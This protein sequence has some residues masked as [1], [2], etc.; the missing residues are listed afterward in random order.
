MKSPTSPRG[1][2]VFAGILACFALAGSAV[3]S[4]DNDVPRGTLTVDRD[5][6][7]VGAKSQ[8]N[9]NITYPTKAKDLVTKDPNGNC[10]TKTRVRMKVRVLAAAFGNDTRFC[11]VEGTIVVDGKVI[12]NG[13]TRNGGTYTMFKGTQPSVKPSQIVF[14]KI[15]EK[16]AKISVTGYAYDTYTRPT[17][18]Y[19]CTTTK[20][21]KSVV[22]LFDGEALPAHQASMYPNMQLNALDYIANY[23]DSSNRAKIGINQ[24]IFLG[25]FN[26]YG[27]EGYDLNDYVIIV[28]LS[29]A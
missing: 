10:T 12:E 27:S 6:I 8:L 23:L 13:R 22:A 28:T 18:K 16:D 2:A 15:I 14:D 7:R 20:S 1:G 19:T 24:V 3:S 4:A 9:W 26:P 17:T 29:E 25:D 5:L 21:D 11:E